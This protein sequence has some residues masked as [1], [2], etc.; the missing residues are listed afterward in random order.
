MPDAR[1]NR[2]VVLFRTSDTGRRH[3]G[4]GTARMNADARSTISRFF[5]LDKKLC[6]FE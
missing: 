4:P 1:E 6:T 5:H 2:A 3:P